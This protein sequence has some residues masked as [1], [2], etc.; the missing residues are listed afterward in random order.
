MI[1]DLIKDLVTEYDKSPYDIN[2]G[3]CED[4][5][6]EIIRRMGG[7]SPD[8]T[9]GAPNDMEC[10]LPGHYWIEYKGKYYDAECPQGV[11]KWQELPIFKKCISKL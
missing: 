9:D 6:L 1:C 5:A 7:Y 8:L 4:F 10:K 3:E 11:S 2:N